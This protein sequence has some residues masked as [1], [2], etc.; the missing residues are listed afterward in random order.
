M[1]H[2]L[3]AVWVRDER[4]TPAALVKRPAAGWYPVI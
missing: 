1:E 2:P 4:V 3:T